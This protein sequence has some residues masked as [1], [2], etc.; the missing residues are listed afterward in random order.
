[1]DDPAHKNQKSKHYILQING[2]LRVQVPPSCEVYALVGP[3]LVQRSAF[4]THVSRASGAVERLCTEQATQDR[5]NLR[6]RASKRTGRLSEGSRDGGAVGEAAG[7]GRASLCRGPTGSLHHWTSSAPPVLRRHRFSGDCGWWA[8]FRNLAMSN[9]FRNVCV[10]VQGMPYTPNKLEQYAESV[11]IAV[12]L[13]T[14]HLTS[15]A[16]MILPILRPTCSAPLPSTRPLCTFCTTYSDM[17]RN[18]H[19][20]T[21]S[22]FVVTQGCRQL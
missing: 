12:S 14:N 18:L 7:E 5:P 1:M 10:C 20:S 8:L 15:I 9:V 11:V 4:H 17:V 19:R 6:K 3:P 22:S 16:I 13:S 21:S 2:T